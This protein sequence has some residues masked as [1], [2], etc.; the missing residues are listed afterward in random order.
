M[1]YK[2]IT[3]NNLYQKQTYMYSEYKGMDFIEEYLNSRQSYL[4]SSKMSWGGTSVKLRKRA[5]QSGGSCWKSVQS[6]KGETM[7]RG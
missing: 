7:T 1:A 6:W 2:Y 4:K 3:D 5:M